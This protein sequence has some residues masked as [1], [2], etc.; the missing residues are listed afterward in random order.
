MPYGGVNFTAKS[1]LHILT[2][3]PGL[4]RLL[5]VVLHPAPYDDKIKFTRVNAHTSFVSEGP[6]QN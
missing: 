4:L 5:S 6:V 2:Y 1:D 3:H